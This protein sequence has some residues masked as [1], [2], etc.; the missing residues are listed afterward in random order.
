MADLTKMAQ[1]TLIERQK[2]L[3]SEITANEEE[4]YLAQMELNDIYNEL[5]RRKEAE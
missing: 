2:L 5:D 3:E 1:E 4:I